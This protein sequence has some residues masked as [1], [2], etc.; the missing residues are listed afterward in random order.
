MQ[1][2]VERVA[3]DS[4]GPP[5]ALQ[6]AEVAAESAE[7]LLA[8]RSREFREELAKQ[9]T[10]ESEIR[11]AL[12]RDAALVSFVRYLEE[13]KEAGRPAEARDAAFVL[14]ADEPSPRLV[15][16]GPAREIDDAVRAWQSSVSRD[17][18][19]QK[20]P[21]PLGGYRQVA[22]RLAA[23]LWNPVALHLHGVARVIVT[24]DGA[25]QSV[26]FATLQAQDGDY[27]VSTGPTISYVGAERDLVS[28]AAN[29]PSGNSLLAVGDPAFG[30]AS[31]SFASRRGTSVFDPL[32]GARE[33]VTDIAA[34][35]PSGERLTVL[36][37]EAADEATVTRLAP[38]SGVLHLATHAYDVGGPRAGGDANPLQYSG[39]ALAGANLTERSSRPGGVD[40]GIL[41]AEEIALLDLRGVEWAVLSACA[42]GRGTFEPGEGMLGLERSF[43]MAGARNVI[44]S[45]WPVEDDATRSWMRELYAA[46][47]DG[48]PAAEAVRHASRALL[49]RQRRLGGTTHPYTWGGFI[50]VGDGR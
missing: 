29:S 26:S 27:L 4:P 8:E 40:D 21:D 25:S 6:A 42:S 47:R 30:E 10:G 1:L 41:T 46:R 39:L 17:P 19:L 5:D 15:A 34:R 23:R 9:R 2:T 33:E 28:P 38:G 14:R 24:R 45:L 43:R 36:T 32:P 7:R 31:S 11:A 12:P 18:R 22:Q 50:A 49:D 16:L 3:G 13:P 44:A 48:A 37:G 20:D 35:W